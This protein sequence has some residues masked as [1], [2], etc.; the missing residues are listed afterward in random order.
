MQLKPPFAKGEYKKWTYSYLRVI[1]TFR[2]P[3]CPFMQSFPTYAIILLKPKLQKL[4]LIDLNSYGFS[5]HF[6][7]S[8]T[9]GHRYID[10]RLSTR[11]LGVA[12]NIIEFANVMANLYS[13]LPFLILVKSKKISFVLVCVHCY[14]FCSVT[15]YLKLLYL[16][17][18]EAT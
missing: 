4:Y 9:E 11:I 2:V 16:F 18:N 1:Y 14:C 8:R 13:R 3:L 7:V 5:I 12:K 6:N 15:F 17:F 10:R